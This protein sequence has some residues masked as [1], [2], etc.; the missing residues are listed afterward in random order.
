MESASLVIENLGDLTIIKDF[1][2]PKRKSGKLYKDWMGRFKL[3]YI[4]ELNAFVESIK[5][6]K[7]HPNFATANDGLAASIACG[8]GVK[9]LKGYKR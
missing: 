2:L 5:K 6:R 4:A 8:L 9:S 3:A 1:Y 7:L